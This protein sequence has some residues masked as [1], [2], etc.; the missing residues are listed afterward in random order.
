M[1]FDGCGKEEEDSELLQADA[2]HVDVDAGHD[3]ARGDVRSTGDCRSASLNEECEDVI[4]DEEQTEAP[5][6]NFE[7]R[8][9]FGKVIYHSTHDHV[10]VCV[11]PDRSNL[12][13][14]KLNVEVDADDRYVPS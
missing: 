4:E 3:L 5:C 6:V 11:G 1:E 9:C 10:G 2:A 8:G 7:Y 12:N 13:E 14:S